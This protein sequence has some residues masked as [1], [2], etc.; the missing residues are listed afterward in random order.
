MNMFLI[1]YFLNVLNFYNIC[2]LNKARKYL[3]TFEH[4]GGGMQARLEYAKVL[5]SLFV[6]I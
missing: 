1:L 6:F 2:C 4:G 5:L 3:N